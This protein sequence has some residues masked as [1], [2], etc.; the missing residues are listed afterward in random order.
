MGRITINERYCKGCNI[1]IEYCPMKV[2]EPAEEPN[3]RGYFVPIVAHPERCTKLKVS[4]HLKRKVC[5]LCQDMCPD[6]A[7]DIDVYAEEEEE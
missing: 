7:I 4:K 1:C 3:E 2:F 5:S 6:F